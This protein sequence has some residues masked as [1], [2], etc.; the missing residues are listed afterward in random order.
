MQWRKPVRPHSSFHRQNGIGAFHVEQ[1]IFAAI[2]ADDEARVKELIALHPDVAHARNQAGVS[3]LMQARYENKLEIAA[4]LR[5]SS[6]ELDVFEAAA[7]GDDVRL[8][9]LLAKDGALVKVQSSDGFTPLHLACFFGQLEAAEMLIQHQA[10]VNAVSPSR[11]AVIHSAA[12]SRNAA[13]LRLVLQAG[14]NP[15]LQQQGG[16]TALHEAAMH[17]SVDRAQALLDAGADRT[18]R[19]DEGLTAA[20][21][22]AQK[23]NKEVLELLTAS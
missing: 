15:N 18:I 11:I 5:N 17:N 2:S 7:L 6:A 16:Y 1:D 14:A 23:G 4:L 9:A 8:H 21:M 20:E 3:A 12:A 13:L 22:A 19:S 10:D